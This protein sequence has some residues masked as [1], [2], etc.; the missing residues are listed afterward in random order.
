MLVYSI[1][2]VGCEVTDDSV[3]W[4]NLDRAAELQRKRSA[5]PLAAVFI[6]PRPSDLFQAAHIPGAVNM[7]VASFDGEKGVNPRVSQFQTIVVYGQNP[8]DPSTT[9]AAKR[10]LKIGYSGVYGFAGG[11]D[12]WKRAALPLE[13]G[14][15]TP[16]PAASAPS[17]RG[18][19]G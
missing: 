11:V 7:S 1:A 13:T 5:D 12:E 8:G 15:G 9:A 6:D 4:I 14:P 18:E 17:R 10:L 16:L 3:N 19:S 2:L